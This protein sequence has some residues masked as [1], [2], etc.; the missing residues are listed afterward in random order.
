MYNPIRHGCT[1]M[2]PTVHVVK[3]LPGNKRQNRV[4]PHGLLKNDFIFKVRLYSRKMRIYFLQSMR[5]YS[6][7]S[8]FII[9]TVCERLVPDIYLKVLR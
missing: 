8:I 4:V 1:R 6:R 3:M 7:V 9:N 5:H 2:G